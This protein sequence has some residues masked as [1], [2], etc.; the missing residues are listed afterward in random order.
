[1][2]TFGILY[3]STQMML[4]RLKSPAMISSGCV[5]SL[6]SPSRLENVGTSTE[7]EQQ[8]HTSEDVSTTN[9]DGTMLSLLKYTILDIPAVQ[10]GF[11]RF[12]GYYQHPQDQ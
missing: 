9:D 8:A 2:I 4:G 12:N 1:M 11:K 6:I 7:V 10:N 5:S 3:L